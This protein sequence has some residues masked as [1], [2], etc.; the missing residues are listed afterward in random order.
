MLSVF[1]TDESFSFIIFEDFFL[2]NNFF[3]IL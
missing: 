3:L 2:I 1:L